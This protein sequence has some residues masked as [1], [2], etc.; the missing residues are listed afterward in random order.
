L[1]YRHSHGRAAG[2][3][4]IKSR[5]LLQARFKASLA[6]AEQDL[7]FGSGHQLDS[8]S[9]EQIP[10]NMIGRFSMT[11]ITKQG[12]T[13]AVKAHRGDHLGQGVNR[14]RAANVGLRTRR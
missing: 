4:V 8:L 6:G 12:K 13:H 5:G 11:A 10:W 7:E 14:N 3:V 9:A 2:A 1:T